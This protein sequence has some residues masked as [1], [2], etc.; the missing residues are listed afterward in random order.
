[1]NGGGT[2]VLRSKSLGYP[3][4]KKFLSCTLIA[5]KECRDSVSAEI[6][7]DRFVYGYRNVCMVLQH[8]E[9]IWLWFLVMI[10]VSLL[11]V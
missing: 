4:C 9:E 3:Q 11:N 7:L 2:K 10:M 8:K 5:C 1:M 6:V